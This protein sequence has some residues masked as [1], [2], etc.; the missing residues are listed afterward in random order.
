MAGLNPR[1]R[2]MIE[3]MTGRNLSPATRRSHVSAV[4]KFSRYCGRSP[5]KLGL[6][7]VRNS[8]VHLVS[9]GVSWHPLGTTAFP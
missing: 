2:R 3:E 1:R 5:D 7:E 9:K 4:S 8:R 6:D